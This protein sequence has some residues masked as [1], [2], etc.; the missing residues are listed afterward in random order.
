MLYT[1]HR[2]HYNTHPWQPTVPYVCHTQ[3][4]IKSPEAHVLA[5]EESGIKFS[6]PCQH[7]QVHRDTKSGQEY[8]MFESCIQG[9]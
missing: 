6:S 8:N 1:M 3:S 2:L 7:A 9:A 5:C 4:S